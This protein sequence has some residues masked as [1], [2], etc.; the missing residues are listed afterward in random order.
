MSIDKFHFVRGEKTTDIE[1]TEAAVLC[2]KNEAHTIYVMWGGVEHLY[3]FEDGAQS[4]ETFEHWRSQPCEKIVLTL[5]GV[6][7]AGD[8]L[9]V[10]MELGSGCDVNVSWNGEYD[11]DGNPDAPAQWKVRCG[12]PVAGEIGGRPFCKKHLEM[13]R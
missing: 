9:P 11:T 7:Q 12:Q 2:W 10:G 1:H 4:A 8:R 13:S 6:P 5:A 3:I